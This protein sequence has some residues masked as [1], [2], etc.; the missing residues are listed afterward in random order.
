MC[1]REFWLAKAVRRYERI[2]QGIN[3]FTQEPQWAQTTKMFDE[4]FPQ[5]ARLPDIRKADLIIWASE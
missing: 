1:H 2:Q 4:A 3:T 5:A